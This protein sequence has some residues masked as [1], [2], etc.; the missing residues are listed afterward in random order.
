MIEH[1]SYI[2]YNKQ[3]QLYFKIDHIVDFYR[4]IAK[5][6]DYLGIYEDE[7]TFNLNLDSDLMILATIAGQI[8]GIVTI[9]LSTRRKNLHV[10]TL[11]IAI[12]T[13]Y[14]GKGI[15]TKLMSKA[16]DWFNG[17]DRLSRLQLFVRTDNNIAI[18]LYQK[19]GFIIEG[20]L[21]ND[22]YIDGVYY[23]VFPMSLLK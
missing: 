20:E 11:A 14:S 3:F 22:T 21:R 10:G 16:I 6:T 8:V 13:N 17:N 1:I 18:S 7:Y 23:N 4:K 2:V 9:L 5:Q 15:G 12:D 19:L